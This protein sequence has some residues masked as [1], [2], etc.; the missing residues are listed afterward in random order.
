MAGPPRAAAVAAFDFDGTITR[1][2]STLAFCLASVRPWRLAAGVLLRSPWLA[3]FGLGLVPRQRAKEALLTAFFR[4]VEEGELRRR[5]ETWAVRELPRL[6][7]PAALAR[8]RWHQARGHRVVLVSASLEVI[9]E[10]W[11]RTVGIDDVLASRLERRDGRL[12]GRLDGGNCRGQVKVDRLRALVGDLAGVELFAYGDS[13][14]DRELLD[15]AQH[16]AYRPF[17]DG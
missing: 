15:A 5:A 10:P 17:R 16:P 12:T 4:G 7:Q 6:V 11:A 1:R 9:L 14:G 2:D 8:I 13:R 3:G